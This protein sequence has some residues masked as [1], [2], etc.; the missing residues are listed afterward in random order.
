MTQSNG[1]KAN[2]GLSYFLV[3]ENLAKPLSNSCF[4]F[5]VTNR[6]NLP[7]KKGFPCRSA[8]DREPSFHHRSQGR[9]VAELLVVCDVNWHH[10]KI[11][12]YHYASYEDTIVTPKILDNDLTSL[13]YYS[14]WH[15]DI[16]SSQPQLRH[17][18]RPPPLSL[19]HCRW[20]KHVRLWRQQDSL[21]SLNSGWR[22]GTSSP[23]GMRRYTRGV[24][25]WSCGGN[26][27]SRPHIV[28]VE[29]TLH[30]QYAR[31]LLQQP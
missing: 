4:V 21:S 2:W 24:S 13:I 23:A 28:D 7:A 30:Q 20:A 25:A 17:W 27:N 1:V 10:K 26:A 14:F 11:G 18:G 22:C 12:E 19:P 8:S 15:F 6:V 29:T 31:N 3:N 5:L 16:T 9:P